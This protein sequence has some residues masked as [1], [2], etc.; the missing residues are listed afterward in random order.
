MFDMLYVHGT[1]TRILFVIV[2]IYF[3]LATKEKQTNDY[4]RTTVSERIPT[5]GEK[6]III[7]GES[8]VVFGCK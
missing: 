7:T 2:C 6:G 4:N 3:W 1:L 5:E 8:K